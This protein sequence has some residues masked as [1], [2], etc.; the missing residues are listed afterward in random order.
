MCPDTCLDLNQAC[1]F[2][3][4]DSAIPTMHEALEA[5]R[6]AYQHLRNED[7]E[8]WRSLLY[9][10]QGILFDGHRPI[11]MRDPHYT[12]TASQAP[13]PD[14]GGGGGRPPDDGGGFDPGGGGPG[15]P[16]NWR[17]LQRGYSMPP[18]D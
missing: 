13:A 9:D 14:P 3:E 6:H 12:Q 17:P 2:E 5:S 7:L 10:D 16:N 4:T 8:K 11:D 15:P 18:M 1:H